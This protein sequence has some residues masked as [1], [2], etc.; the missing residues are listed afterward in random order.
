MRWT[1]AEGR[2]LEHCLLTLGPEGL[3]LEGV[4]AGTREGEYGAHYEVRTDASGRTRAV[5]LRY[6][7]GPEL[8]LTVDADARWRDAIRDVRLPD[9]DG[10]LDV[11][12]GI[13]PAT[14]TLAIRRLGL[15]VGEARAIRAAY[16]PLPSQIE[17]VFVP[18]P[19]D[20]RYTRLG[21]RLW[22]YEGLFR[23]FVAEL[24]VDDLGLVLDYPVLFRRLDA[25]RGASDDAQPAP[26]GAP[27]RGEAGP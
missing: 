20:Q 25:A 15:S 27:A 12:L 26:S 13:T 18:S 9:L 14:N 6:V 3:T 24:P 22:R 21:D 10:C 7:G 5:R 8:Q 16:V 23:S 19:A 11:D 2:G 17:G 4:V 1:D